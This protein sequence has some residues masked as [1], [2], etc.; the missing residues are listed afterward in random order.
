MTSENFKPAGKPGGFARPAVLCLLLVAV[1]LVVYWPVTRCDFVNYDDSDYF[2]SNPHVLAGLSPAN[3]GWAFTTGFGGNWHPLTWL[4]LMLDASLFGPGPAGPH[5]T[6][7]LFHLADTAL[8]FL[9]FR[10]LTAAN[11]RSAFVAA[12]FALHPLHVESVA[13]IS[14]RK[15]VLSMF[16][17]LLALIAYSRYVTSDKWQVTRTESILSRVTCHVSRFY[18]LALLF[19][20]LGLMSKPMLVTLPFVMLLL[21]YW[22]LKRFTIYDLRFTIL[23]LVWEKIPFF[24]LSA[25]S[26]LVTFLVQRKVGAVLALTRFSVSARIGNTFV[27][28]ARYLG[29]T[30][31]PASLAN[32]YPF[33]ERWPWECLLP[34]MVLLAGLCVAAVWL[35][36]KFPFGFTGWFWFVGTLVPVIGLVQ[37]GSQSMAD[38]YSYLPSV[39]LFVILAWGVGELWLRRH[40]PK[41]SLFLLAGLLLV[42]CAWQ[43]RIQLGCWQNT[44][45]LFRHALVVTENNY[46]ACVNLGT[47]LSAKGDIQGAV[48]CY[49]QALRMNPLDPSVLYDLGNGFAKLGMW[50]EA[51][52]NYCKALEI[53]PNQADILD[54]LGFARAAKK[55]YAGAITN[56]EAAL[57]LK[58]DSASAHN[59]LATVLFIQKRFDEAV[60]HFREAL[61]IMPGNPQICSNLGDALVKQGQTTEA[62]RCYQEALRL[63]PGDPQITA[64]LQALG[65]QF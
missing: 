34:A 54:N 51:I 33:V 7:L 20:A 13:W 1:T 45:T 62:V 35:A 53:T 4:S 52:A 59:N 11:W 27:S 21:D 28:Y 22:P 44:E 65:V 15:D 41:L 3:L 63:K 17:G 38:R 10:R 30:F 50:D 18:W 26:C 31:W 39:G 6:N 32:P 8:V 49:D 24:A 47:C 36:R 43:T 61:R 19:F 37:V 25:V 46:T 14:E 29:K 55:Q 58:P 5:L 48:S 42:A 64:K 23:R 57:K 9:L 12:L 60:R 16:F 40:W 56:F 2:F